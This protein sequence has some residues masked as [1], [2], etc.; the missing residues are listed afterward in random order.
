MEI[1]HNLLFG[2]S[3]ALQ[4]N[5]LLMCF[6]GV[7]L[8]TLVGV[9][10]GLGPVAAMS[11][12]L[13]T[14]YS[15]NPVSAVIM[16]A[17]IYYGAMY[18]GSTTSILLNIPGE[19]A[20]VV[21][22]LDGYQMARHGRAGPALGISAMGSFIGG[23]ISVVGLMLVAPPLA[24][25]ALQF[26]PPEYFSLMIMGVIMLTFLAGDSMP[27]ALCMAALGIFLGSI[28]MD[29]LSGTERFTFDIPILI[30]G[31]GLVPVA[32]GLFGISEVLLNVEIS[33]KRDIFKTSLKGL[34]PNLEDWRQSLW[35]IIRGS[36]LGF[37]LGILPGG[38]GVIASFTSYAVE[39]RVSRHPERFGY[40]AIEGVAGPETANNA[41]TGGAFIPLLTLGLPSNAVMAILLGAM[42]IYGMQPGPMLI[43]AH[44]D[45]FWGAI[46]SMYIGNAM[47]LVLNLPLI[48]LWVKILKIPYRL[49]FPLILLF[50]LV[51]AY[52]LNNNT[53][54]VAMMVIFGVLG[55]FLRKFKYPL[56]PAILAL[57]LG[58][59]LEKALR[60]SLL[61][62]VGSGWIFVTRP[63]S[64]V[65]LLI[66]FALLASSL[67]PWMRKRQ[68]KIREA[69]DKD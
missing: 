11:L 55:Y 24:E 40:G 21:T 48:G 52:S 56:A 63:I 27:K 29:I 13:P 62:S 58:P 44:P 1:I 67:L 47:L 35:P 26:G 7:L 28:G 66:S 36:V 22:C 60:Q 46:T 8:G 32:M 41:G 65:T 15:V 2:F 19:A 49:L 16:L 68:E 61:M 37:F 59:M 10:P 33:L 51:G 14:T 57:V 9:L 53:A 50:C 18:G 23:T 4:P 64:L 20:S 69:A 12:L 3:V 38:G 30:D 43:K 17:G 39:K 45:L 6:I 5:S 34:L 31:V 25:V 54:E 42:L